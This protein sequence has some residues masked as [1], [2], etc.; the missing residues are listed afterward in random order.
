MR[1][2]LILNEGTGDQVRFRFTA[3]RVRREVIVDAPVTAE[4]QPGFH[5]RMRFTLDEARAVLALLTEA[6]A[7]AGS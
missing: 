6:V 2:D 5:Y 7:S 1:K 4:V 3:T